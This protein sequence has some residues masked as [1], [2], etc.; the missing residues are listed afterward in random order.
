M[1]VA[2]FDSDGTLF[3]NQ[4]GRGMM[5]YAEMNGRGRTARNYFV[6]LLP[7]YYLRKF[8]LM[9]AGRYQRLIIQRLGWLVQGMD[10]AQGAAMFDW[11]AHQFLLPSKREDTASR[12]QAHQAQGHRVAIVSGMFTPCLELIGK[13]FG[14]SDLIGTG[15]EL[16]DGLYTGRIIP[17]VISGPVKADHARRFFADRGLEVDWAASYAYGDSFTDRELLELVGH[18]VAVHPDARLHALAQARGWEVLGIPK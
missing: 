7:A 9:P 18:P 16:Q 1:I 8:N 2:L 10:A 3:A 13:H 15:I 14:V 6:S 4:L 12:L 17:P 11:V 5:K